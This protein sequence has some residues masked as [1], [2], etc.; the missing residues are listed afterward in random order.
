MGG[1]FVRFRLEGLVR[2]QPMI[3]EQ[4]RSNSA[5]VIFRTASFLVPTLNTR[6][7]GPGASTQ[8]RLALSF[9][10]PEPLSS[11]TLS[12]SEAMNTGSVSPS[13]SWRLMEL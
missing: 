2:A 11:R 9:M 8:G 5:N 12:A 6:L 3:R 13:F 1:C 4:E 10:F 7:L